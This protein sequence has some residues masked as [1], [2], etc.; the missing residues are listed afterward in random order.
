[1]KTHFSTSNAKFKQFPRLDAT[2]AAAAA[3]AAKVELVE[4]CQMETN[5]SL[6]RELG[7]LSFAFR[8]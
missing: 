1:M 2:A 4:T 7:K 8:Q 3:A 6:E 5:I